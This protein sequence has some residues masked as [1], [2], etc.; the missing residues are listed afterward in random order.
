M[1]VVLKGSNHKIIYVDPILSD[2]VTQKIP[3]MVG[4][5]ER[6]FPPPIN[7]EEVTNADYVF[8]THEH[9]DHTDPLTLGPLSKASPNARFVISGWAQ[10]LLDE[11]GIAAERRMV[12]MPGQVLEMDGVSVRSVAAAH[13]QVE[14]DPVKGHRWMSL[15]ISWGDVTFFH[16]GDTL[17]YPGYIEAIRSLPRADLGLVASNG[18]NAMREAKDILGNLLPSEAIW[19]AGELGWD[20]LLGGHNDLFS[21]NT[22]PAGELFEAAQHQNSMQKVHVLRPGELYYYVR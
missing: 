17:L 3:E 12:P 9:L 16:S 15:L 6:S 22:L 20:V 5:M 2:V 8:C 11:A 18:R 4:L 1:G 7:P 19:M 14:T 21:Y 13:Y 10:A